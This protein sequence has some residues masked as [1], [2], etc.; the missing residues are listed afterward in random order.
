MA[1]ATA[2]SPGARAGA[3]SSHPWMRHWAELLGALGT[4]RT[5]DYDYMLAGRRRP[6]PLPE[7]IRT[8]RAALAEVRTTHGGPV[9]L[10]GKS[11]GSRV[12]CHVALVEKID[13][14]VC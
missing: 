7:L 8:H 4:V 11:M 5:L 12:G 13:A 10:A 1:D 9:I 14:L 2:H 3:P 6:D